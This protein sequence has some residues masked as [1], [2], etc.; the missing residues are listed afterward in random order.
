[1]PL[2]MS[3]EPVMV[4][5]EQKKITTTPIAHRQPQLQ[6]LLL[7][8]LLLLLLLLQVLLPRAQNLRVFLVVFLVLVLV[9]SLMTRR[10]M[11]TQPLAL[12]K[13]KS[14]SLIHI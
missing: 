4:L 10:Q 6:Q 5:S 11:L 14:L 2:Q 3:R 1:M 9:A 8:L 12:A 13:V 7:P